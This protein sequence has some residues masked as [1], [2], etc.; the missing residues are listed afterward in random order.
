MK[1]QLILVV[2][3]IAV[4]MLVAA[5]SSPCESAEK[6][7]EDLKKKGF[8]AATE[9]LADCKNYD[10]VFMCFA[11]SKKCSKSTEISIELETAERKMLRVCEQEV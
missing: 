7:Y 9:C 1:K 4:V 5:C 3:L 11:E 10:N 6:K 8:N 2:G